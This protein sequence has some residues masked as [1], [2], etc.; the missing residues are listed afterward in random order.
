MDEQNPYGDVVW[1]VGGHIPMKLRVLGSNLNVEICQL[2]LLNTQK[3]IDQILSFFFQKR[4][5]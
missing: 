2:N 4:I 5:N 1:F 3:I